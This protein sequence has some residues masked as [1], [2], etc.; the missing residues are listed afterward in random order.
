MKILIIEDEAQ[1]AWNLKE[2][3]LGIQPDASI[4]GV[5][6]SLVG[7]KEW[8]AHKPAPE[9]IFSDIHL[10]DGIVFDVYKNMTVPC[11]IIFCTAYDEYLLQAF[12]TNGIDYLLKPIDEREL[13]RSFEKLA[14]IKNSFA[15]ENSN[16]QLD[17]AILEILGKKQTYKKNFL[18]PHRDKL[19][20]TDTERIFYFKVIESKSEIGLSDGQTYSHSFTLDYLG[21]VLDPQ[22]FYRVSRQYLLAFHAIHEIEHYDDRKLL[23]RLKE[24]CKEKIVVSKAKA[25]DFLHWMQKR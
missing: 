7:I 9:L 10:G 20:P 12:K 21:T 3:I 15:P 17:S 5:V 11:P 8:F 16:G 1:A 14:A 13:K 18:I 24:P 2:T 25:S 23:I 6:D 19:I 22:Q 4:L